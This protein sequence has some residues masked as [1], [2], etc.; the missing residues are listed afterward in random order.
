M[1]RGLVNLTRASPMFRIVLSLVPLALILPACAP[2]PQPA[3]VPLVAPTPAAASPAPAQPVVLR[4][5]DDG[6]DGG[7]LIDGICL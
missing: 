6:G 2:A 5:C 7:V 4:R 3:S 1:L